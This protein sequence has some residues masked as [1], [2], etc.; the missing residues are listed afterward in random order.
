MKDRSLSRRSLVRAA[1]SIAFSPGL[2]FSALSVTRA[3][4]AAAGRSRVRA[5]DPAWPSAASWKQLNQDVG[6]A[7]IKVHSPLDECVSSPSGSDCTQLFKAAKNPYFLGDE[8][9]LTQTFGWVDAWVS[10]PS[11]YA[12]AA[13]STKDVMA[14]VNFARLNNLRLVVKGGGHSYQ[15]TSNAPDS[16]LVWAIARDCCYG[17]P[18]PPA[19]PYT[20][21]VAK[22]PWLSANCT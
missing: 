8:V 14:A 10:T 1:V 18:E 22:L 4:A 15:G 20:C 9:G 16:L 7:L 2:W 17:C 21:P 13:R 12:V 3:I 5:A 6:G 19:A 11:I